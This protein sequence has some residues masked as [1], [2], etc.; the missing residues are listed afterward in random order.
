MSVTLHI[1]NP[2]KTVPLLP[3]TE[4]IKRMKKQFNDFKTPQDR[5]YFVYEIFTYLRKDLGYTVEKF[6]GS[7]QVILTKVTH[8]FVVQVGPLREGGVT[9]FRRATPNETKIVILYDSESEGELADPKKFERFV[10][11]EL[12]RIMREVRKWPKKHSS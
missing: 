5:K 10:L 9:C 11:N 7:N 3:A 8:P 12:R 2:D 6:V 1:V 4:I